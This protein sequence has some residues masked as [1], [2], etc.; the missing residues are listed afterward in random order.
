M[1]YCNECSH[2][3]VCHDQ[4]LP[5]GRRVCN[6]KDCHHEGGCIVGEWERQK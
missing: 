1:P 2:S 3:Y 5:N 4:P 6:V